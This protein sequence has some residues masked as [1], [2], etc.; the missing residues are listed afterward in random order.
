MGIDSDDADFFLLASLFSTGPV[1]WIL[2]IIGFGLC[3]AVCNAEKDCE[4]ETCEDGLTSKYLDGEC[5]CVRTP[6]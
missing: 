6:K 4:A 3:V 2:L 5:L 1:G